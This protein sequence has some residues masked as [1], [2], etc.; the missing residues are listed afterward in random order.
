[1]VHF[2]ANKMQKLFLVRF[3]Y[4]HCCVSVIMWAS[5]YFIIIIWPR[6]N[7]CLRHLAQS[8]PWR[9]VSASTQPRGQY[10]LRS[11][12]VPTYIAFP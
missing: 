10:L 3:R 5:D 4:R 1:M 12:K 11:C 2:A 8:D 6:R 9:S 7:L